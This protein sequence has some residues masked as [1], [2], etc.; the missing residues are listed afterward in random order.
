MGNFQDQFQ[1]DY[2]R[3]WEQPMNFVFLSPHF[4]PN[5]YQF[6]VHLR[7]LGANVL[8]LAEEPYDRLR[9][10]LKHALTDYYKVNAMHDYAELVRALGYFTHR[11]GKIDRLDSLNEY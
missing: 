8:G 2:N 7:N 10:E 3:P 4:P 6:C 9:P 1:K 5:Y 11:Y